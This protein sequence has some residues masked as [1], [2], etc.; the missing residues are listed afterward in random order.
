[1]FLF[2]TTQLGLMQSLKGMLI[3][4]P[5]DRLEVSIFGPNI[6]NMLERERGC[7][8]RIISFTAQVVFEEIVCVFGNAKL[9]RRKKGERTDTTIL[10]ASA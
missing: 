1:M 7:M 2:W 5:E 9:A 3:D 6:I 10:D 8:S 4:Y